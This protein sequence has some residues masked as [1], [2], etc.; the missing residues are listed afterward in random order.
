MEEEEGTELEWVFRI[1]VF[2]CLS[3][4]WAKGTCVEVLPCIALPTFLLCL[5]LKTRDLQPGEMG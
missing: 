1:F 3:A 5:F 2:P 4:V